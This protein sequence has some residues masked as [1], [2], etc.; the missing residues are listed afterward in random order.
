MD[1]LKVVAVVS[2]EDNRMALHKQLQGLGFIEFDTVFLELADAVRSCQEIKPD[3]IIVELTGREL[4]GGLFIQAIGMDPENPCIILALHKE[5]DLEIFKEAIKHGAKEFFQYPDD[6]DSLSTTLKKHLNFLQIVSSGAQNDGDDA[7]KVGKLITVFSPK[8]GSGVTTIASNLSELL[9]GGKKGSVVYLD[10]D[11]FYCNSD[12]M[13]KMRPEYSLG[14]IADNDASEV[15]TELLKKITLEHESGIHVVVGNK[16]VLDENDMISP[17]LLDVTLAY[18]MS[19]Y[20]YI[21]VD[22]PN[23]ILD[24]YHQYMVERADLNLLVSTPDIPSLYRTRQYLDLAQKHLNMEKVKLVIN[25]AN[26]KAAYG[27]SNQELEVQFKYDIFTRL[28]ND[29]ELNVEA[30]SIG[31]L[32]SKVNPKAQLVKDLETLATLVAGKAEE[33]KKADSDSGSSG[34]LNKLFGQKKIENAG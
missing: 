16:S 10:M 24:P 9:L 31:A 34:L 23:H 33:A 18:M 11:Q 3:V 15:D 29:W 5:M 13:L 27:I 7:E 1:S 4:D 32:F 12:L 25:R 30:N 6:S 2:S 21:I 19:N 8:G 20:D 26:L 17:D 28:S 14:D 22:M